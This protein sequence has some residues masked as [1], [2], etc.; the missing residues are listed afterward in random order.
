MKA[1]NN[2]NYNL[3]LCM[4]QIKA[5]RCGITK[6]IATTECSYDLS[7]SY[8]IDTYLKPSNFKDTLN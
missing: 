7:V 4:S 5:A 1:Y 6:I 3:P 8:K 2:N